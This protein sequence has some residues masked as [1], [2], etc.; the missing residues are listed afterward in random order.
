[1]NTNYD[2]LFAGVP[3]YRIHPEYMPFVGDE[4]DKYKI[5]IIGESHY[6]DQ[7][8]GAIKYDLSYFA[9]HWWNGTHDRLSKE[10]CGRW[11]DTRHVVFDCYLNDESYNRSG[12][13][14][15]LLKVFCD[16][17]L[18]EPIDY[19]TM[20]NCQKFNCFSFMNFFQMPS[21]IYA[22]KFWNALVELESRE[23]EASDT[24]KKCV[25]ESSQVLDSVID[26]LKPKLIVFASKSAYYA[27]ADSSASHARDDTIKAVTHPGCSW[28][29]RR[30]LKNGNKT[31]KE[32]FEDIMTEYAKKHQSATM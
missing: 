15:N 1:M 19:I 8:K 29:N 14:T 7:K 9:E 21:P 27:F 10:E 28:W 11:F 4:Y 22:K 17:V 13:F 16:K 20:E 18:D 24:W 3:F 26:I 25:M 5:L 23:G 12:I 31:G 32:V 2:S 30:S 6:I